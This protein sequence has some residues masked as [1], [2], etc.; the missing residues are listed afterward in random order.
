MVLFTVLTYFLLFRR[1]FRFQNSQSWFPTHTR[2]HTHT[3][4]HKHANTHAHL[5]THQHVRATHTHSQVVAKNCVEFAT[6]SKTENQRRSQSHALSHTYTQKHTQTHTHF[7]TFSLTRKYFL[8]THT[9]SFP[10][11]HTLSPILSSFKTLL[12]SYK[13]QRKF[14][15]KI[16]S[17]C[18]DYTRRKC[19]S[20]DLMASVSGCSRY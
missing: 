1:K 9:R 5:R 16:L 10:F 4:A 8:L 17:S 18:L 14:I 3:H 12:Y 20:F 19:F 11:F 2:K 15:R 6:F 13:K 7:H